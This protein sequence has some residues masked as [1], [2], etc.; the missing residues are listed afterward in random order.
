MIENMG[1][2]MLTNNLSL[3]F[4]NCLRDQGRIM[5]HL[6]MNDGS[7]EHSH[8]RDSSWGMNSWSIMGCYSVIRTWSNHMSNALSRFLEILPF[9]MPKIDATGLLF[10]LHHRE[11]L[12]W[13]AEPEHQFVFAAGWVQL[14]QRLDVAGC[15]C[16]QRLH[17]RLW[18]NTRWNNPILCL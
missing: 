13:G 15:L 16:Q 9:K 17:S 5:G 2:V 4:I 3:N 18:W 8:L 14:E 6:W 7:K 1:S 10:V 11:L 12:L